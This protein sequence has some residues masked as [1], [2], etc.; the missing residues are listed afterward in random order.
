MFLYLS[1]YGSLPLDPRMFPSGSHSW[2]PA[3][4]PAY[5][6]SIHQSTTPLP[7]AYKIL[8]FLESGVLDTST[9][10]LRRLQKHKPFASGACPDALQALA[11]SAS[12][13]GKLVVGLASLPPGSLLGPTAFRLTGP[14]G[15]F[16]ALWLTCPGFS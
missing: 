5:S 1:P 13:A 10:Q 6:D 14:H 8:A 9:F 11:S 3:S 16:I 12:L 7:A 15:T 2:V 4:T